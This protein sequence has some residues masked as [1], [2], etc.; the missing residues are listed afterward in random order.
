MMEDQKYAVL[1]AQLSRAHR[2]S[3]LRFFIF[4][5]FV[6][7]LWIT[8]YVV[9][10]GKFSIFTKKIAVIDTLVINQDSALAS[11]DSIIADQARLIKLLQSNINSTAGTPETG[12]PPRPDISVKP[13][14]I[15]ILNRRIWIN[16]SLK[17]IRDIELKNKRNEYEVQQNSINIQQMKKQ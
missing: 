3:W 7:A 4:L 17:R 11:R 14:T 16:D 15:E 10:Q 12:K 5:A 9:T 1:E 13:K 2:K 6:L 8:T